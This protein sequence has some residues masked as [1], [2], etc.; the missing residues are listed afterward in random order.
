MDEETEVTFK[1]E[2]FENTE[3][4]NSLELFCK[5][6][7]EFQ[8]NLV[9]CVNQIKELISNDG[10]LKEIEIRKNRL[11]NKFKNIK[12]ER[13]ALHGEEKN[14]K[15]SYDWIDELEAL[16]DDTAVAVEVFLRTK[17]SPEKMQIDL[18]KNITKTDH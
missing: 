16:V 10:D 7:E 9:R 14:A 17:M 5:K 12:S 13:D 3:L 18:N 15:F 1:G 11:E 2:T 4:K 8:K 6:Q